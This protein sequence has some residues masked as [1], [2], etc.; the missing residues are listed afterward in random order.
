MCVSECVA[1]IRFS[2]QAF[3]RSPS[4]AG[5]LLK[6]HGSAVLSRVK[7]FACAGSQES[8]KQSARSEQASCLGERFSDHAVGHAG[9]VSNRHMT[10]F[11]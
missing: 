11:L 6:T 8:C 3:I 7:L 9:H 2:Q 4:H 10:G 1:V 5:V